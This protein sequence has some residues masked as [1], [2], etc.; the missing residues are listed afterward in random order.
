LRSGQDPAVK[1]GFSGHET[2][3]FR[4]TWLPKGVVHLLEYPDLFTKE[5]ALVDL[6]VGKNMVKSIRHWCIASGVIERVDHKGHVRVTDLGLSLFG[7]EGWDSFLEDP[8]T[9]WLLHWRLVSRPSPAWQQQPDILWYR[10]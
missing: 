4:Y 6:G 10:C 2:F 8:G 3:P 7:E 9:L 5:E 1:Y